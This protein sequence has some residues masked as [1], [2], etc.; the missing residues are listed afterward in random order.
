MLD[1]TFILVSHKVELIF[2]FNTGDEVDVEG[3]AI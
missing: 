2:N 3:K 1:R